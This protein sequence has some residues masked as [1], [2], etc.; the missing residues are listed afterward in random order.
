MKSV[1]F[2]RKEGIAEFTDSVTQRGTK[3]L[4]D[5]KSLLIKG[6]RVI[7]VYLIQINDSK[8]FNLAK[9]ID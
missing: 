2:S 1:T 8:Y 6:D 4:L 3:Q 9:D 5:M 7:I